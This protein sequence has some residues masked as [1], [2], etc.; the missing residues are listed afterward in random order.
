MDGGPLTKRVYSKVFSEWIITNITSDVLMV[1]GGEY[2]VIGCRSWTWM[3]MGDTE[4]TG[5]KMGETEMR[6]EE[7]MLTNR[8]SDI[9]GRDQLN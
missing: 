3:M 4:M 5:V 6:G 1:G 2:V 9:R 8:I 7:V